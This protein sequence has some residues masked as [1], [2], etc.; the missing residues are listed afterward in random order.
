MLV[1]TQP[2]DAGTGEFADALLDDPLVDTRHGLRLELIHV[3]VVG[4]ALAHFL[5]RFARINKRGEYGKG[6]AVGDA[7][8]GL[9]ELFRIIW[10]DVVEL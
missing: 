9:R 7:L 1:T 2:L 6:T 3:L 5:Q 8:H 10:S 4:D